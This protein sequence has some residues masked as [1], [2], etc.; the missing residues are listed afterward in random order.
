MITTRAEKL[1]D[2]GGAQKSFSYFMSEGLQLRE[3][4][5]GG[6]NTVTGAVTEFAQLII[7]FH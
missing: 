3:T 4:Q 7:I 5:G 1:M 2:C 6:K